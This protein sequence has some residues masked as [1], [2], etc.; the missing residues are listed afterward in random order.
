MIGPDDVSAVSNGPQLPGWGVIL[1]L[2]VDKVLDWLSRRG[3]GQRLG[4]IEEELQLKPRR[5]RRLTGTQG[6]GLTPPRPRSDDA[7]GESR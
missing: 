4:L 2:I 1:V 6:A 3:M 5:R 7:G